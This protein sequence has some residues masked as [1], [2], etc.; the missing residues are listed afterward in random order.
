MPRRRNFLTEL[1]AKLYTARIKANMTQT[2]LAE[3]LS[4]ESGRRY[5]QCRISNFE[6]GI[7]C[8]PAT[9][10]PYLE[11]ILGIEE[12][13]L[14]NISS[15]DKED[16]LRKNHRVSDEMMISAEN[17]EFLLEYVRKTGGK[18]S[19]GLLRDMLLEQSAE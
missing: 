6:K 11:K 15:K 13:C 17:I 7:F 5:T 4:N 2:E 10:F 9:I 16:P 8:P 3:I 1:G 19:F 18:I 12:D 14:K